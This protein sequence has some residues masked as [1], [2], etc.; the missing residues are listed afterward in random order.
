M[1]LKCLNLFEFQQELKDKVLY[2]YMANQV[3]LDHYGCQTLGDIMYQR[4]LVDRS[5]YRRTKSYAHSKKEARTL[6][7]FEQNM[8]SG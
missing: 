4:Q 6:D 1:N 8:R 7:R 3:A 5:F 2:N